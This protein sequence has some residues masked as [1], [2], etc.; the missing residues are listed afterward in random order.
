MSN[1]ADE[2]E[3]QTQSASTKQYHLLQSTSPLISPTE[4]VKHQT[5]AVA[6]QAKNDTFEETNL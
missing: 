6:M 1:I 5:E 2:D 4:C 3:G